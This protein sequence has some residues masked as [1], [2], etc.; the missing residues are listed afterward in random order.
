VN[1]YGRPPESVAC[2]PPS[3]ETL[4]QLLC[5]RVADVPGDAEELVSKQ[6][7]TLVPL[8][9][10]T[11]RARL[12]KAAVAKLVGLDQ[13][14]HLMSDPR[15]DE[16]LI[17]R[18]GQ[19][20]VEREGRLCASTP[21]PPTSLAV[22][23]ERI[24]A[25]L[26]RRL[27]RSSPIV[28]AR[29]PDG[30][31]ICAVVPP[32]AVDGTTIAIRRLRRSELH[33]NDFGPP[34]VVELL[35]TLIDTRANIV[36]AGGTSSGKTSLL[37]ALLDSLPASERVVLI[38]DTTEISVEPSRH[39]VRLEARAPSHEGPPAV[40]VG[41]LVRTALRLRPDRIVV[42]EVRGDEI[43]GL[44]HALNTGHS[45]SISTCHANS[46]P[47]AITRLE[48]LLLQASPQWP[49]EVIRHHLGSC[50]DVVIH[51]SRSAGIGRQITEIHEIIP[52]EAA[53]RTDAIT[54]RPLY[55]DGQICEEPHRCR[56]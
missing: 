31:R 14:D 35:S 46:A 43:L 3:D 20:W 5:D 1:R 4:V 25:P 32:V 52:R 51:L 37:G 39:L 17:N 12:I 26:G 16:I 7:S 38:E 53:H 10:Q 8:L 47:E 55:V 28:D 21:I 24:L 18:S 34:P 50:I 15:V 44:V 42:G 54:T 13:L 2:A 40:T 23:L 45:G 9:D 27:D 49:I 19:V 11:R 48:T 41:D 33:I 6:L 36:I 30:S 29:L 22:V 56:S